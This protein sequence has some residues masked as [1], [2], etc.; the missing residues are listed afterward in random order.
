MRL[1]KNKIYYI[2]CPL[3]CDGPDKELHYRFQEVAYFGKLARGCNRA[4]FIRPALIIPHDWTKE[5]AWEYFTKCLLPICDGIILCGDWQRSPGCVEEKRLAE[6]LGKG[7]YYFNDVV[8]LGGA[9]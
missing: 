7:V 5:T 4:G 2:S 1:D 6:K 3:T 9:H 8:N